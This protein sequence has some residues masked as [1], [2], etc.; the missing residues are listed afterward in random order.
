MDINSRVGKSCPVAAKVTFFTLDI[1]LGEEL[2][3]SHLF[4]LVGGFI[5]QN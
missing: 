2:V 4:L 1:R 5:C 3:R